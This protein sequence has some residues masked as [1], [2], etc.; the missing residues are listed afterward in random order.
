[1]EARTD[2][3]SRSW[4]RAI[5]GRIPYISFPSHPVGKEGETRINGKLHLVLPNGW[6]GRQFHIKGRAGIVYEEDVEKLLKEE[7]KDYAQTKSRYM[8]L[9]LEE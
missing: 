8:L 9:R 6:A 1:M 2:R 4:Q 3:T 5:L 7:R